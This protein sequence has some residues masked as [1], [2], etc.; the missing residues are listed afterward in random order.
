[1]SFIIILLAPLISHWSSEPN[2]TQLKFYG[3]KFNINRVNTISIIQVVKR[4][5]YYKL[6]QTEMRV[7]WE[8]SG[9]TIITIAQEL[10]EREVEVQ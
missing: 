7:N 2:T 4:F 10:I 3:K 8:R 6:L 9:G 5:L 1:M